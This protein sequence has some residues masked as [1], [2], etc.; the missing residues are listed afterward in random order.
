[1]LRM[2]SL[3]S[4]GGM[5]V[6]A[7]NP[8]PHWTSFFWHTVCRAFRKLVL[9][10]QGA[11]CAQKLLGL[12]VRVEEAGRGVPVPKLLVSTL[13]ESDSLLSPKSATC[14]AH[15]FP[16]KTQKKDCLSFVLEDFSTSS[17]S[18]CTLILLVSTL[19]SELSREIVEYS[20][21][22]HTVGFAPPLVKERAAQQAAAACIR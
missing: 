2:P 19:G 4:S 16:Q 3:R 13:E 1:M 18:I 7:R 8:R 12:A 22:H 10:K 21:L 11:L 15:S 5:W 14:I 20:V 9:A 17:C 6:T